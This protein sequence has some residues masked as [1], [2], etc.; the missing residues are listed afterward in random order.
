[1]KGSFIMNS[2]ERLISML[3][4]MGESEVDSILLFVRDNF[5]F[6]QK[7][8]DDIEEDDPTPDEIEAIEKYLANK[9][10]I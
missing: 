5:L 7:S 6:K 10:K 2:K 4:Y 3:D 9:A 8:W 1:M